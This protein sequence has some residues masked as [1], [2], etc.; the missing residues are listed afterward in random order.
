MHLVAWGK[1]GSGKKGLGS[2][3]F[4]GM[5]RWIGVWES[6]NGWNKVLYTLEVLTHQD[7]TAR[8]QWTFSNISSV[9]Y[10]LYHIVPVFYARCELVV[11]VDR[12]LTCL[13]VRS[14]IPT[15]WSK[16]LCVKT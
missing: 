7:M 10:T 16:R 15:V 13:A 11:E 6:I 8:G 3:R 14:S 4:R 12:A 9:I 5:V 2:G 1:K